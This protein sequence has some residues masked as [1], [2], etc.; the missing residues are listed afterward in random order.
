M[1]TRILTLLLT[2]FMSCTV[3]AESFTKGP[4]IENYGP[5]VIV[6]QTV[7]VST[8]QHFNVVFDVSKTPE[9]SAFNSRYNSLARF[10]NM[11]VRAGVPEKNIKLALVVHGKASD[12]L[13]DNIHYKQKFGVDNPNQELLTLLMKHQVEIYLCGQSAAFNKIENEMLIPGV[14]MSLSAMTAHA[15]LQQKG[16]TLNPF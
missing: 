11:H 8:S 6:N 2:L 12:E 3:L 9:E 4:V 13:L 10:L 5:N 7:P 15:L 1:A 14:Q 16:Y